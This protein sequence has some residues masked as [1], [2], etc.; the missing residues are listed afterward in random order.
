MKDSS[1]RKVQSVGNGRT[2][3]GT[4]RRA[5]FWQAGGGVAGT[6]LTWLLAQDGFLTPQL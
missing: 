2:A 6:A 3:C 1:S 4:E 5:F